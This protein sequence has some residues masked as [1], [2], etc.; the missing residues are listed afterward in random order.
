LLG[1]SAL[2][3]VLLGGVV[4]GRADAPTLAHDP[5]S[6]LAIVEPIV[7]VAAA[8]AQPVAAP[9]RPVSKSRRPAPGRRAL[10]RSGGKKVACAD[11]WLCQ[12]ASG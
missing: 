6:H 12:R 10:D 4:A 8:P 9:V 3:A 5:P 1:A 11:A 2:L 7:A